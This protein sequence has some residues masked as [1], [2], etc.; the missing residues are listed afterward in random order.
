MRTVVK[1]TSY[2][3]YTITTEAEKLN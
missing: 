3:F 2:D 1:N